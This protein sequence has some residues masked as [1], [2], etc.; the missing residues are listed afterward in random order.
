MG[1]QKILFDKASVYLVKEYKCNT[2]HH[3]VSSCDECGELFKEHQEIFCV[4]H[5]TVDDFYYDHF[6]GDCGKKKKRGE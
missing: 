6:C 2:C 3:T 4:L 1:K 5:P